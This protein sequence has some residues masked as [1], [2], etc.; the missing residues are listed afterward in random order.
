MDPRR[1]ATPP[2]Y[3]ASTDSLA[4]PP[5]SSL[6]LSAPAAKELLH[7]APS[8][9]SYQEMLL[10]HH[11]ARDPDHRTP[12]PL[13]SASSISHSPIPP[14]R[15]PHEAP[16]PTSALV[17]PWPKRLPS[18]HHQQR[19]DL[20]RP[21]PSKRLGH[22]TTPFT[23]TS[24]KDESSASPIDAWAR[25]Y[26]LQTQIALPATTFGACSIHH[27]A[28]PV[29]FDRGSYP[30]HDFYPPAAD[31]SGLKSNGGADSTRSQLDSH[32]KY[33][34]SRS[35]PREGQ[36]GRLEHTL[37]SRG[38]LP[39][40]RPRSERGAE[41]RYYGD[42]IEEVE[43]N[44]RMNTHQGF[45]SS[46][47]YLHSYTRTRPPREILHQLDHP[48]QQ[49]LQL[50]AT[51]HRH[52]GSHTYSKA[53]PAESYIAHNQRHTP[54][55]GSLDRISLCEN[56]AITLSEHPSAS[57]LQYHSTHPHSQNIQHQSHQQPPH[58]QSSSLSLR[59]SALPSLPPVSSLSTWEPPLKDHPSS[60]SGNIAKT[61]SA[62][63]LT[64]ADRCGQQQPQTR[65]E[66]FSGER[67]ENQVGALPFDTDGQC[68]SAQTLH[69]HAT[70]TFTIP[71]FH[72]GQ[73]PSAQPYRSSHPEQTSQHLAYSS[74]TPSCPAHSPKYVPPSPD[75]RPVSPPPS[76]KQSDSDGPQYQKEKKS[77]ANQTNEALHTSQDPSQHPSQ[78]R[79]S[80]DHGQSYGHDSDDQ[81]GLSRKSR[82]RSK[83]LPFKFGTDMPKTIDLKAAIESCD[84]LC[85][86]A[87]HYASQ[88]T[89]D[90]RLD[91]SIVSLEEARD[92][93]TLQT[94]R[95]LNST[96]L[97]GSQNNGR[98]EDTEKRRRSCLRQ[99]MDDESRPMRTKEANV[100][101][102]GDQGL[103]SDND[104]GDNGEEEEDDDDDDDD[105]YTQFGHGP[106]PH[107]MV[108][109][110]AKAA[111]S[112]FQLAIR[113]KAWVGMTPEER[114]LDEDINMI[115]GKRCLFMDGSSMMRMSTLDPHSQQGKEWAM[116][117]AR[118]SSQN[119]FKPPGVPEHLPQGFKRQN[120][121]DVE[122]RSADRWDYSSQS[123]PIGSFA[124]T[125][126]SFS[127]MDSSARDMM[128]DKAKL[129]SDSGSKALGSNE[130]N[131]MDVDAPPQ[132]YRKRAKR[133]QPPGRCL[134]CDSS[135]TPEWRRGPDGARTLCN[136]CGLHYAKL[137][138]R[139]NQQQA[140]QLQEQ[141]AKQRA[142][143][144]GDQKV[145]MMM[146]DLDGMD[147]DAKK[148]AGMQLHT[149]KFQFP[150][151]PV[152][153]LPVD[154]ATPDLTDQDRVELS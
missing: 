93:A 9:H 108:H 104:D 24:T 51:P 98:N 99:S 56:S 133:T 146:C 142:L 94:I 128:F 92:R 15:I 7:R 49:Q 83:D 64:S 27:L 91:P 109:E 31:T 55:H 113:I 68:S 89:R 105:D 76:F 134:S 129:T 124:S 150:R 90:S 119:L 34:P 35:L 63:D 131:G 33:E 37:A 96:I 12:S 84:M 135:D 122:M 21:E 114:V 38:G 72:P 137:V 77:W 95:T 22:S 86:F 147:S 121:G 10:H 5:L 42:V 46:H 110:L 123:T 101:G 8:A 139:Q 149:I 103:D 17:T 44:H 14:S 74:P 20:D 78:Q 143:Q 61:P 66:R 40:L 151:R 100:D 1:G 28:R 45:T 145:D 112:I 71:A 18:E 19:W 4:L 6:A 16:L 65:I 120:E 2:V 126:P 85:K 153:T 53:A 111:T 116:I 36:K 152:R 136:A 140:K 138:K 87:L 57:S 73:H 82:V 97:I 25:N 43:D 148:S 52:S 118:A 47:S 30:H 125:A 70:Q 48:P 102:G 141:Q 144:N 154:D 62:T 106:P 75:Y 88:E 79:G 130:H 60:N 13:S 58:P 115:R 26:S 69:S 127:P 29:I 23:Q 50:D 117:Q 11:H 59:D 3:A 41:A 132:K 107:E 81:E 39:L 67:K 32:G 80:N 54:D